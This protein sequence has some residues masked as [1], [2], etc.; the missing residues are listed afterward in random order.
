M[1]RTTKQRQQIEG[2]R[3]VI[4]LLLTI[5]ALLLMIMEFTV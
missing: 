1:R 5:V 4:T 3:A 2:F